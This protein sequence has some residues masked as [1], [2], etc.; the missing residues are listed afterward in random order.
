MTAFIDIK[1]GQW[2]LA[3]AEYYGP[4]SREMPEHLES[5]SHRGGG[6][7]S[8]RVSEILHVYEVVDVK[9]ARYHPR[10]Y[11]I[12]QTIPPN[13]RDIIKERQY[14]SQ[15]IAAGTKEKM[16]AL[17]DKLFAIGEE[18]DDAIEAEMYRRVEKFAERK[19]SAAKKKIRRL[20]PHFFPKSKGNA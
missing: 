12:G 14:R 11:A 19:Y 15:V 9:S 7:D 18:A 13:H 5:F 1:P 6:W 17:R 20:F 2:V 4:H 10:T 3:F 16:V 8:H